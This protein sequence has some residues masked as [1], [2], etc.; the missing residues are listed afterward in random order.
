MDTLTD[1]AITLLETKQ[2]IFIV[3][4]LLTA[5]GWLTRQNIKVRK[6]I[7]EAQKERIEEYKTIIQ[8][9]VTIIKDTKGV[10]EELLRYAV[11]ESHSG[12]R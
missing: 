10:L 1:L 11:R 8:E 9:N 6:Q 2:Y 3:L 7:D 4:V 5:I 12:E